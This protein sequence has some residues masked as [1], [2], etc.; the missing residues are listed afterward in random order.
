MEIWQMILSAVLGG[1]VLELLRW[2]N[3]RKSDKKKNTSE[4]TQL[5]DDVF[6]KRIEWM[7]QRITKLETFACFDSDCKKRI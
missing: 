3:T 2:F 7:E 1:G 5:S 4:A 6:Y